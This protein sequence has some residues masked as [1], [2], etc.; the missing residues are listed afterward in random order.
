MKDADRVD[1]L[2]L[3]LQECHV[4]HFKQS[5]EV[6][7]KESIDLGWVLERGQTSDLLVKFVLG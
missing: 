6:I 2:A 4:W 5:E 1:V 3:R 7:I